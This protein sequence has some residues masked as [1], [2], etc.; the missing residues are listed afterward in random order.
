MQY[1]KLH[2]AKIY[3]ING[4]FDCSWGHAHR[5]RLPCQVKS[6]LH[7]CLLCWNKRPTQIKERLVSPMLNLKKKQKNI[8]SY[9]NIYSNFAL[10]GMSLRIVPSSVPANT[11]SPLYKYGITPRRSIRRRVFF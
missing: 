5:K 2:D 4:V 9:E 10:K 1:S 6:D 3:S 7:F 8:D 11:Y